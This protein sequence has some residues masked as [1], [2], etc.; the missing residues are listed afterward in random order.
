MTNS[1]LSL[2]PNDTMKYGIFLAP[3]HD[4][5]EN[6][7]QA[8]QRDMWLLEYLDELGYAE[9]WIGEHHSGGFEIIACPEMFIAGAAERTKNIK[10]GTGVAHRCRA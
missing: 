2:M 9:A 8:M 4:L 6:P 5:K 7:T 10:L 1:A 3:F